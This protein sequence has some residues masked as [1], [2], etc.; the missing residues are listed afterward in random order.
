LIEYRWNLAAVRNVAS[1]CSELTRASNRVVQLAGEGFDLLVPSVFLVARVVRV[2]AVLA[3]GA[4]AP[5]AGGHHATRSS[6][7]RMGRELSGGALL[8]IVL[9]DPDVRLDLDDPPVVDARGLGH[10]DAPSP[11]AGRSRLRVPR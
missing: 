9:V 8:V 2:P 5:P 7:Y 10:F 1:Q 11:S 4:P 3:A 6:R